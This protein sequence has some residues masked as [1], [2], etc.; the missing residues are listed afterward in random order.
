[1]SV[2]ING[3]VGKVLHRFMSVSVSSNVPLYLHIFKSFLVLLIVCCIVFVSF[4][5]NFFLISEQY[6]SLLCL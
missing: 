6:F 5:V 2:F 3:C 1:M 4:I